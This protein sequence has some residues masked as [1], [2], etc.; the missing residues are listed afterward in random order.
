MEIFIAKLLEF[1]RSSPKWFR[2]VFSVL[3]GCVG[4][5]VVFLMSTTVTSCGMVKQSRIQYQYRRDVNRTDSVFV[6]YPGRYGQVV[7]RSRTYMYTN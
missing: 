6:E 7:T 4:A 2:V 3:L 5:S 1:L